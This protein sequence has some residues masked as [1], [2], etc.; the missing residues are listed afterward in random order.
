M[1][2]SAKTNFTRVLLYTL[3]TVWVALFIA[4]LVII[5]IWLWGDADFSV[6]T[7]E[8]LWLSR[9]T[10]YEWGSPEYIAWLDSRPMEFGT[11][12]FIHIAS[13]F[14]LGV[15]TTACFYA[16]AKLLY[17]LSE[18]IVKDGK[19]ATVLDAIIAWCVIGITRN[20]SE[21]KRRVDNGEN[22]AG[23]TSMLI[24]SANECMASIGRAIFGL[25]S[26]ANAKLKNECNTK[27]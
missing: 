6:P 8:K 10:D 23:I 13:F 2:S 18:S 15:I 1:K 20:P 5:P 7:Q 25:F 24:E 26:R 4:M 27:E 11:R 17:A 3:N 19:K 16:L 14:G 9:G 21:W 22:T 12:L